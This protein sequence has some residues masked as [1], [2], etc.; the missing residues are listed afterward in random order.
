MKG[1]S[2]SHLLTHPPG[3]EPR[4]HLAPLATAKELKTAP[5]HRW[6]YFPHSYSPRLIYEVL[7]H[8]NFP[9]NGLLVDNFVGSGTTLLAARQRGLSVLGYDLSPLAVIVAN[10]KVTT[11]NDTQL[12][13]ALPKILNGRIKS[14]FPTS[15]RL[16][17]AFTEHEL[18]ELSRLLGSIRELQGPLH[19]FFLVAFLWT[20]KSFSRAVP[21]GGWFRWRDWPNRGHEV[22]QAFEEKAIR[23]ISDVRS[24]NWKNSA[25]LAAARIADARKLPLSA[26][27][28]DGLITSPPYANRH[29]YSRIFQIELLFLGLTEPRITK[30]RHSAFRSHVEAKVPGSIRQSGK[31]YKVPDTLTEVIDRLPSD[32]DPRIQPLL[33]G[34]FEDVYFSLLEVSR[35]LKSGGRAAYVLGNVRHAGV[36]VP[37]DE[38]TAEISHQAGLAFD[39][40]W[41]MRFRGNS[42][43]QMGN[44]GREPARETIVFLSRSSG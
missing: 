27:S 1:A 26:S 33:E 7:D 31:A 24:L 16:A 38:I 11:Y 28:V 9:Q 35:I 32:A 41:I 25:P 21:D 42:A 5:R 13:Q 15:D 8:W 39:T 6:F 43:Q 30:L 22:K 3:F 12:G 2:E 4:L 14:D 23:M 34:Y 20:A 37:V 10:T 19:H 40:A 18:G 17:K 29:D 36:M 44:Y